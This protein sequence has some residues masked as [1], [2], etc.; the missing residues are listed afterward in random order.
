MVYPYPAKKLKPIITNIETNQ[1]KKNHQAPSPLESAGG[2][3]HQNQ[4]ML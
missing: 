3:R 1:L 4:A 2:V